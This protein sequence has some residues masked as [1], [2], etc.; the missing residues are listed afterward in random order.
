[1]KV[2]IFF[3][4]IFLIYVSNVVGPMNSGDAPQYFTGR[5]IIEEGSPDISSF[6]GD[7][8]YFIWPDLVQRG[9]QTLNMRG[10]GVSVL[11]M[12]MHLIAQY[13]APFFT[14][15]NFPPLI[16]N[17]DFGQEL[18]TITLYTL[19]TLS[20][21]V[22]I[23]LAVKALAVNAM[24]PYIITVQMAFG[25]YLW[26]YVAYYSRQ[27]VQVFLLGLT[28]YLLVMMYKKPARSHE[29]LAYLLCV[30]SISYAIDAIQF[31]VLAVASVALFLFKLKFFI[32]EKNRLLRAIL[33]AFFIALVIIASNLIWYG[34]ISSS[35][36]KENIVIGK[37]FDGP[38]TKTWMSSPIIPNLWYMLFSY[39]TLQPSL[40]R[41][42]GQI[43]D[44][45][46]QYVSLAYAQKYS[47]YGLFIISPFFLLGIISLFKPR[48]IHVGVAISWLIF[49]LGVIATTKYYAFWGGNLYDV[50]YFY[51]YIV[52]LALP[53][54]IVLDEIIN[55]LRKYNLYTKTASV[56]LL[57]APFFWSFY[58]GFIGALNMYMPAQTGERRVWIEPFEALPSK[59]SVMSAIFMNRENVDVAL[60]LFVLLVTLWFLTKRAVGDS[61]K[62]SV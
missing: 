41:H 12:P 32:K 25:T 45:V 19:F 4:I 40:F 21:L 5:A 7:A 56:V 6:S 9:S 44:V 23:W 42:Y 2:I 11:M 14:F 62:H 57:G 26:K 3:L 27:G 52:I 15:D 58:M 13:I 43:D 31:I 34:Q 50:R 20:G 46:D 8:H 17:P 1:M 36:Y 22:F 18:V 29:W 16:I 48:K 55:A 35:L 54:A 47:F 39:D 53:T 28:T 24:V 30:T 51:P 37:H 49:I 61:K 33:P 60:I 38:I 10:H 59:V